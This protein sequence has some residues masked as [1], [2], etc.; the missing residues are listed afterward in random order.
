M[1]GTYQKWLELAGIAGMAENG[2]QLLEMD[3]NL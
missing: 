3:E 1:T 2:W